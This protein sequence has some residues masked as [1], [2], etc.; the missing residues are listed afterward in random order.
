MVGGVVTVAVIGDGM[1]GMKKFLIASYYSLK[2]WSHSLALRLTKETQIMPTK[3]LKRAMSSVV[4]Q[5]NRMNASVVDLHKY[6]LTIIN[7][8][9]P[10]FTGY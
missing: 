8:P 9:K 6:S 10:L 2:N 5:G 3:P 7:L 1:K 4:V